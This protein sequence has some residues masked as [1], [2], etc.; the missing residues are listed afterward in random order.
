MYRITFLYDSIHPG[1][2]ILSKIE[3]NLKTSQI[4]CSSTV[5]RNYLPLRIKEKEI[6]LF[7]NRYLIRIN[8]VLKNGSIR[9]NPLNG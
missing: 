2:D 9:L 3:F 4:S 7:V 1:L 6:K 5:L 8:G